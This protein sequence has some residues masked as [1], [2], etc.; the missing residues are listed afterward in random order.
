MLL[1]PI[2]HKWDIIAGQL[3]VDD[4]DIAQYEDEYD[5]TRKLSK[6]IQVW[7][8]GKT[9]DVSWKMLISVVDGPPVNNKKV[10]DEIREFLARPEII[11]EYLSSDQSGKIE[12][13]I[14]KSSYNCFGLP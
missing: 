14:I 7:R 4:G 8:D 11:N 5:K 10:A 13:I 12:S 1:H 2:R 3:G 9:S 6:V